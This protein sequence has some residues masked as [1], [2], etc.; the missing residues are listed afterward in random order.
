MAF[1]TTLRQVRGANWSTATWL[2]IFSLFLG[3]IPMWGG[4]LFARLISQS[5][6]AVQVIDDGQLVIYSAALL[7]TG[8]YFVGR[9]FKASAFPGRLGFLL[10]LG[11]LMVVATLLFSAVTIESTINVGVIRIDSLILRYFSIGVFFVSIILVF[12]SSAVNES[13]RDLDI[14]TEL[15]KESRTLEERFTKL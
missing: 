6:P 1:L 2:V 3:T 15:T 13:L 8:L 14:R 4:F 5:I 9:D 10:L 7:S 11:L 12:V